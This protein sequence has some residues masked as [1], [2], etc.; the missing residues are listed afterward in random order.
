MLLPACTDSRVHGHTTTAMHDNEYTP[1]PPPPL[2]ATRISN[3]KLPPLHI[4][5]GRTGW[6]ERPS[7]MST[8]R[9]ILTTTSIGIFK[10]L[11]DLNPCFGGTIYME[12]ELDNIPA[13]RRLKQANN[14]RIVG[15]LPPL[16][17]PHAQ[18][19]RSENPVS[20]SSAF[21]RRPQKAFHSSSRV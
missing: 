4:F 16:P 8:T 17:L 19:H 12:Y 6:H 11:D 18:P 2:D 5:L 1:V 7:G 3:H 14:R 10:R 21:E 15:R 13:Q 9:Y 20:R